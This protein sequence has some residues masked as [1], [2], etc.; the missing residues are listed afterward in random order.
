[1]CSIFGY[2]GKNYCLVE[3]RFVKDLQH[4]GPDDQGVY[5]NDEISLTLG[6]TRL[7]IIDLSAKG[8]QPMFDSTNNF[9]IVFNGEVYNYREIKIKLLNLG[10]VF[11]TE[12]DTEVVLNSF[13][14]WGE[15][16][17]N[18]FRGMFAFCIFNKDKSELFLARDRFGIKPLIYTFLEDQFI[19]CSELKPIIRSNF[20]PKKLSHEA[21]ND[22]FR[23]GAVKQPKTII[24]G[25]FQLLPGHFMKVKS[26]KTYTIKKYYDLV[27]S[28][29]L[30]PQVDDYLDA[31]S[32]VRQELE[33]ATKYHMV[34]DVEV[35]VFL[36]GGVDS[37][38][39]TALMKKYSDSKIS[40][41]SVG[42]KDKTEAFDETNIA[43]RTAKSLGTNHY[44]IFIDDL[45]IANIFDKFIDDIDQPSFDGINTYI[46]SKETARKIKVALSG[47]GGD[48]I[49]AGYSHFKIIRDNVLKKPNML[50]LLGKKVNTL[51]PNR[52]TKK[53]PMRGLAE[54]VAIYQN[55]VLNVDL[56]LVLKHCSIPPRIL[57]NKELSSIQRISKF[58][59]DNYLLDTLLRD[60]DVL[61]MASSLEVRPVLLD[62]KLVELAFSLKDEYKIRGNLLK[63]VFVESVK[64]LIPNEVW[65]RKKTGFTMP[66]SRW[67][68]SALN[69]R[70]IELMDQPQLDTVFCK[71]YLDEVKLKVKQ[72]KLIAADWN[73]FIFINWLQNNKI[74][75]S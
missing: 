62:H 36:S 2:I 24:D 46:V 11:N 9:I 57:V 27:E 5:V 40:T 53:Y 67:M 39:V 42:F 71:K 58:E 29:L 50:S 20:V 19:F 73:F 35:G 52:F 66:Y 41:F 59:I 31:V 45:Y 70:F 51:R 72:K 43:S 68:N 33:T 34:G 37:T 18:Y 75:I 48:E 65:N 4:R 32:V 26:D 10:Y 74:D 54:E 16:C 22:Y 21:T 69:D 13:I 30:L 63:S 25:V 28:S 60:A 44:N 6:Q 17:M 64:D 38:S 1:M 7:S 8:H 55:R 47:L 14:E 15:E 56:S 49:F 3:N 12:T 23:M 61:S